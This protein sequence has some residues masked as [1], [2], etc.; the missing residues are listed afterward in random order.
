MPIPP[1]PSG[2]AGAPDPVLTA[3]AGNAPAFDRDVD[4]PP[5]QIQQPTGS[6]VRHVS[7]DT[8]MVHSLLHW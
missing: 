1:L 8:R 3:T 6:G 4:A 5:M 7:V 2:A